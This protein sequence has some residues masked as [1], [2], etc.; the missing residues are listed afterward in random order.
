[1]STKAG[2]GLKNCNAEANK[3]QFLRQVGTFPAGVS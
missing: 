2:T 1:M 3:K